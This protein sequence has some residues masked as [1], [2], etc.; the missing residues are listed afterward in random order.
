M[1][2]INTE[3]YFLTVAYLDSMMLNAYVV[4]ILIAD[5]D[6]REMASSSGQICDWPSFHCGFSYLLWITSLT[7]SSFHINSWFNNRSQTTSHLFISLAWKIKVYHFSYWIM[8]SFLH[9]FEASIVNAPDYLDF[10][11]FLLQVW[12]FHIVVIKQM[13]V[14]AFNFFMCFF[15]CI[16]FHRWRWYFS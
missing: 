1:Q 3:D 6:I 15:I 4:H 16:S 5:M 12:H 2:S 11:P 7:N 8:Q 14:C 13:I 10:F 9:Q